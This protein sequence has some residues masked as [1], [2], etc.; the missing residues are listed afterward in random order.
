MSGGHHG[1]GGTYEGLTLHPPA[2]WHKVLAEAITGTMWFWI[3]VRA[4]HD[5]ETLLFGHARHF[6]H[7]A[8]SESAGHKEQ[9]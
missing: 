9:H 7:E 8:H 4:Y 2:T 5:G 3:F 1:P 6:E